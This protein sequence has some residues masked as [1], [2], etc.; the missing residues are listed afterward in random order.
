VRAGGPRGED[1][2]IPDYL[3]EARIRQRLADAGDAINEVRQAVLTRLA[4]RQHADAHGPGILR[5]SP[6]MQ[7]DAGADVLAI[8]GREARDP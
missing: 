1:D 6:Q 2:R 4:R 3:Q 5:R 8:G 7:F